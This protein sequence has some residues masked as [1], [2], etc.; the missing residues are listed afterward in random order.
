MHKG[1]YATYSALKSEIFAHVASA[2]ASC[3]TCDS[4]TV[5]GHSLGGALATLTALELAAAHSSLAVTAW[6]TG[7]PRVGNTAFA[8][9]Y[10]A[11]VP[12]TQRMTANKDTVV[13]LPLKTQNFYHVATEIW[14][15]T[16]N[17]QEKYTVCN[18]GVW[19]CL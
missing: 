1:Y 17:G 19:P 10:N 18:G 2:M 11:A 7:S 5:T 13:H 12:S 3:P 9:G 8:T 6:T 16:S 15:V 14:D 4:I